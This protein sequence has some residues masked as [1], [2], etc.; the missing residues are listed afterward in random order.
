M[1]WSNNDEELSFIDA[2]TGFIFEQ[3]IDDPVQSVY[4]HILM[5]NTMSNFTGV[6]G[7]FSCEVSTVD[8]TTVTRSLTINR[9]V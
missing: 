6:A 8:G 3:F 9:T 7:S 2:D 5:F 4:H 1:T